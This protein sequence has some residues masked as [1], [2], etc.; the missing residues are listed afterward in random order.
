MSGGDPSNPIHLEGLRDAAIQQGV[1]PEDI[2]VGYATDQEVV[3]MWK[4][5]S[6]D[7][8]VNNPMEKWKASMQE[9]DS[10]MPRYLEDIFNRDGTDGLPQVL[11]DKYNTK[12]DLRATKP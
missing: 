6:A 7:F 2:E 3:D 8:Y 1:P 11:I 5:H 4:E 9:T 10:G 12:K